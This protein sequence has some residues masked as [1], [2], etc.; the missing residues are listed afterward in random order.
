VRNSYQNT[1][2]YNQNNNTEKLVLVRSNILYGLIFESVK[3]EK[4]SYNSGITSIPN[5]IFFNNNTECFIDFTNQN[6]EEIET[7]VKSFFS[8][9]SPGTTFYI[10]NG[11][12]TDQ[13]LE[14]NGDISGE[15]V[16]DEFFKGI[17]RATVTSVSSL[18]Q[19]VSRYDKKYFIDTPIISVNAFS[20]T[21]TKSVTTIRNV[22]GYNT[23]NSFT[24]MGVSIGDYVSFSG[25]DGKYEVLELSKE[26][27]GSETLKIKGT[28]PTQ[29][30]T[31]SKIL[32]NTYIKFN[33]PYTIEP[34]LLEIETGACIKTQNYGI[35]GQITIGCLDNQ[36]VTQCRFRSSKEQNITTTIYPGSACVTP[37]TET[38]RETTTTDK[39]VQITNL[40]ASNIASANNSISSISG[41]I[42]RNG[43]SR[44]SFYGRG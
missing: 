6:N 28:I 43:N 8:K 29:T 4:I 30:K 25:I 38:A 37:E 5:I 32:V 26:P 44:T 36:T 13:S 2:N 10:F 34:N 12:Y 3:Q 21:E 17:I 9:I 22:F 14:E 19:N 15:F 20:N 42:N 35:G 31:E 23:K 16:F 41:P 33:E 27:N 39:L 24:Y 40:L 1:T 7:K 11:E 18:I